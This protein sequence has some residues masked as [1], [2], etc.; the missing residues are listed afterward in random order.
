MKSHKFPNTNFIPARPKMQPKILIRIKAR[1]RPKNPSENLVNVCAP[2]HRERPSKLSAI[3]SV[4]PR[5][6]CSHPQLGI[7]EI[8]PSNFFKFRTLNFLPA[9]PKMQPKIIIRIKAKIR[10]KNPSENLANVC[11]PLHRERPSKLSVL[12]SVTPRSR[13]S[14]PQPKSSAISIRK[15][16]QKNP[17]KKQFLHLLGISAERQGF[18]PW[19]PLPVQRFSRPSRSTTPAPFHCVRFRKSNG[20]ITHFFQEHKPLSRKT[21]KKLFSS[22]LKFMQQMNSFSWIRRLEYIIASHKHI[23]SRITQLNTCFQVYASV[24]LNNCARPSLIY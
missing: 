1:I 20:K 19:V 23:G 3:Q 5:S 4:S 2:P 9:R 22:V 8:M 10:P 14:H 12:Q 16:A 21:S 11:A 17:H 18:E 15:K 13:C 6:R 24:N 7:L